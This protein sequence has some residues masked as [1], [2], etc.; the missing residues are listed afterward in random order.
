M[1]AL[2]GEGICNR[3]V[4]AIKA[5]PIN[6]NFIDLYHGIYIMYIIYVCCLHNNFIDLYHGI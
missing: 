4:T 5:H 1:E 3:S 2:P 6:N